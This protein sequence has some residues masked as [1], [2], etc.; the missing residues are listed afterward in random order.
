MK[1]AELNTIFDIRY[2]NQFDLYKLD[3]DEWSD[4]NF[5]SRSS[6]NLGV[7]A[8]VSRY[9]DVEPFA[10]GLITVTLGG[11]YLLSSFVQQETFY[12]AQNIKVLT[13]KK[14][15]T[16][17]EKIFYCKSI[18]ANRFRYTSHG[19]EANIT[20]N[21]LLVPKPSEIPSWV[22]EVDLNQFDQV[23]LPAKPC[24]LPALDTSCWADF[25][26]QDIFKLRYGVNL[27]LNA[28]VLD[29]NGVNF[30]SRTANNNGVSAKVSAVPGVKPI[31]AMTLT[32]AGGGSVLETFLQP[33]PY[34][35]GRDLYY[36]TPKMP[37]NTEQMLFC[38]VL[39]RANKYRFNYGR[40]AN[41]TLKNIK[42]KLPV[43]TTGKLDL[44]YME[45][46]IK[47][48]PYSSSL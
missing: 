48:L 24:D 16:L 46:Y 42:I 6:Q 45:Q 26:L 12:T 18:E 31:D 32:V 20:L 5:V 17:A 1:L 8:K 22:Y 44:D 13:P 27:E 36:L 43:T 9:N 4:I 15:M 39:I 7:V 34:Y 30:V 33:E 2:G 23:K 14:E 11:T 19:R 47:S 21:T 3:A 35:S 40:Q 29:S 38:C 25:E 41:K 28:M 10:A 37:M